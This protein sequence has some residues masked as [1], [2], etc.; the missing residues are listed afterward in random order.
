MMHVCE[1]VPQHRTALEKQVSPSIF[2]W[3]PGI[4]LRLPDLQRG[5]FT[6][7]VILMPTLLSLRQ[8]FAM[9]QAGLEFIILCFSPPTSQDLSMVPLLDWSPT[10]SSFK[11]LFLFLC[12]LPAC[13]YVY[14][15]VYLVLVEQEEGIRSFGT[16]VI[17]SCQP[18]HGCWDVNL[19]PRREWYT[20]WLILKTVFVVVVV[21]LLFIYWDRVSRA[22]ASLKLAL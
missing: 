19:G 7:W 15:H 2:T 4:K 13:R 3:I 17:G 12:V 11:F 1:C 9:F 8:D 18:P 20:L 21:S 5:V 16:G 10:P 14:H 22:Q 6:H